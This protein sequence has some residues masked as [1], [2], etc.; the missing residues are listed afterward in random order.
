MSASSFSAATRNQLDPLW[1]KHG[2]TRD[3]H[4]ETINLLLSYVFK[5]VTHIAT[6]RREPPLQLTVKI[7]RFIADV[8]HIS[9]ESEGINS[10]L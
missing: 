7:L 9:A 10:L 5:G 1:E 3:E 6:T 2:L 8:I 4:G